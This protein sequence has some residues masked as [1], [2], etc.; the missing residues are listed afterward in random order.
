MKNTK[1]ITKYLIISI[2]IFSLYI[3]SSVSS[4]HFISPMNINNP[5]YIIIGHR[6][7]GGLAPE[8]TIASIQ[9]GL[10][11]NVKRIEIDIQQTL[12]DKIILMHD[13]TLERT[14][15]GEGIIKLKTYNEL[16][17]LDAG[18]WFA[19]EFENEKIP[20]LSDAIKLVNGRAELIIEIKY[21]NNYSHNI[22][23]NVINI[24]KEN[25]AT[26]WCIIHSFDTEILIKAHEIES[27][28]KLHK[29]FVGKLTF[30]PI[31]ISTKIEY[32]D[33]EKYPFITEYS[34]NSHFANKSLIKKLK[35]L[36]KKVNVWTVNNNEKFNRF[37]NIGIDGIVTDFPNTIK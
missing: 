32:Y 1:K 2:I 35:K 7:A 15:N 29:L 21:G 26:N 24:I 18:K 37:I 23:E 25:N 10:D 14:T 16:L 3:L 17:K 31:I 13:K 30:L 4:I 11:N 27:Q 22:V 5:K 6:G 8:N 36:N 12:D 19:S 9:K 28:I 20:L 33:F 34:L